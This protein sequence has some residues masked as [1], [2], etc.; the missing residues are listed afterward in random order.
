MS[1]VPVPMPQPL[2]DTTV[3]VAFDFSALSDHLCMGLERAL[4]DELTV[5][6][7]DAVLRPIQAVMYEN[8]WRHTFLDGPPQTCVF[9]II[10][11]PER[12]GAV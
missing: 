7:R 11:W 9:D 8:G 5:V 12:W 1:L 6:F 2:P 4:A 3:S 10:D